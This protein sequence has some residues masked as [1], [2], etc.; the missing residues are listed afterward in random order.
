MWSLSLSNISITKSDFSAVPS[1]LLLI[2]SL[3]L[4]TSNF[5][6][7]LIQKIKWHFKYYLCRLLC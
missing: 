7:Y 3:N 5:F 1:K 2:V 4:P 6:L